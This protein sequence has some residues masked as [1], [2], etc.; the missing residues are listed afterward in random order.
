MTSIDKLSI[1]GI[2]AFSPNQAAVIKFDKPLT[3]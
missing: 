2:R 3:L 1:R